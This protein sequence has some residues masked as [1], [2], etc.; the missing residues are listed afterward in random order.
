MNTGIIKVLEDL[1]FEVKDF[2]RVISGMIVN[3]K[4]GFAT[5]I[6]TKGKTVG[7]T[8]TH[9][10]LERSLLSFQTFSDENEL[11]KLF[12]DNKIFVSHYQEI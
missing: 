2:D 5:K 11:K 10:I 7:L 3:S 1:G 4:Y 9:D 6:D 12:L 8:F